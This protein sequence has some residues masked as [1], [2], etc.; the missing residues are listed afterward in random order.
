MRNLTR[1]SISILVQILNYWS[2]RVIQ[3][4]A[5]GL[6]LALVGTVFVAPVISLGC[7][8]SPLST[9]HLIEEDKKTGMGLVYARYAE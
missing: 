4:W 9:D 5:G 6:D 8:M 2:E 7:L 1:S 3:G